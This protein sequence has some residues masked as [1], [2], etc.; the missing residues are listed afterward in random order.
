MQLIRAFRRLLWQTI[1]GFNRDSPWEVSIQNMVL[2]PEN[3][4][5]HPSSVSVFGGI[6]KEF[7]AV[8]RITIGKECFIGP[9]T[10]LITQNHDIYNPSHTAEAKPITIGAHCWLGHSVTILPGVVLGDHTTVGAGAVVTHSFPEGH[11]VICG[12]PAKIIKRLNNG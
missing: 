10:A 6:G 9:N 3:I 7:Q 2:R 1:I 11:C 8:A 4:D 5:I 12:V